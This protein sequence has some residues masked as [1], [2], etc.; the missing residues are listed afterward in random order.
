MDDI[1][2][3][4]F[5]VTG[6]G[7]L[8]SGCAEKTK[9]PLFI[10]PSN[11]A[12]R[13]SGRSAY[14]SR[15][16][17]LSTPSAIV[18]PRSAVSAPSI[19]ARSAW[20]DGAPIAS[21]MDPMNGINAVTVHHEGMP[22]SVYCTAKRDVIRE[23]RTVRTSHIGRMRAGDIGYHFIIDRAGRVWEGRP[24]RFQGAHVKDC[25]YHN[26][27]VMVMG[28]FEIQYPSKQQLA[29][30][31]KLLGYLMARYRIPIRSV[32][33]HRE[34]GPTACPGR[35]LQPQVNAFRRNA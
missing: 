7:V 10:E 30:L 19:I 8:V 4:A 2:R 9:T 12:N 26:I 18:R 25:N 32:Y 22:Y 17:G 27:G 33:T 6:L 21:R 35:Y 29:T 23:L 11:T 20:A 15:T 13:L 31:K 14:S 24:L 3:R 34:L 1:S 5:L 28:N 16:P